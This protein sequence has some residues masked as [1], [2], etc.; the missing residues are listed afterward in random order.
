RIELV[1]VIDVAGV[2][3]D[4]PA[5]RISGLGGGYE[6]VVV[7]APG[8][9]ETGKR[10]ARHGR[11]IEATA[12]EPSDRGAQAVGHER[13]VEALAEDEPSVVGGLCGPGAANL[14][15]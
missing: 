5:E 4:E 10:P 8:S 11:Q 7:I 12:D 2:H 14:V 13:I 6:R 3:R 9:I 15:I 1:L